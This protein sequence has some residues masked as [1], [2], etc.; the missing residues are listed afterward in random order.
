[1]HYQFTTPDGRTLQKQEKLTRNDLK[2]KP[3]PPVG[4]RIAIWYMDT[5][6]YKTL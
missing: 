5:K 2:D 4:T 1:M 6:T 3:L